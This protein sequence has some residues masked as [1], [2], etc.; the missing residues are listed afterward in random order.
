MNCDLLLE[1]FMV[2]CPDFTVREHMSVAIT[3]N[4]IARVGS[5]AE[6]ADLSAV[7]KLYGDGKLLM[8]G[9]ID[10]HTHTC[11]QL[12]RGSLADEFP[13]VWVR[14]LVPFESALTEDDVYYSA[15]LYCVQAIKSGVTGFADSGGRHMHRVAQA[16]VEAG[17]RAG[18]TRSMM[19]MGRDISD[20]ML[21]RTEEAVE[22]NDLL[23]EQYH[24]A[25]N[26]R[27]SVFYGMR[28][29]MAC[30]EKLITLLAEHAR[31]RNTCVHGHLCEHRDEVSFC[32]QQYRL[33]PAEFLDRC[34]LLG[35]NLLTAHN[36]VLSEPDIMLLAERG[37]KLVHCPFANLINHGV[38]KTPR[39]L[40]AG[41][42]VGLGSDGAAYNSVDIFEE[43]RVLRA[44]VIATWG[45]PIFDPV[46]LTV[47]K[48]LAMATQG[49]AAAMNLGDSLGAIEPG[50]LADL[51][52]IDTRQPHI[53][54]T[55]SYTTALLDCVCARDVS[56]SIIDGVPVMLDRRLLTLDE[57]AIME[58]C[59]VRMDSI[60]R[61]VGR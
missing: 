13:M 47:Q 51:I 5:S 10:A 12:L 15:L 26:G 43:M 25:G 18:I 49:G 59:A 42:S 31:A 61:R 40:E 46:A 56:D 21:E 30:S 57:T 17:I 9:L 34:S 35:P 27:V 48:T 50:R 16:A 36:V 41:C 45:L 55:N 33:R 60:R 39:L 7:K 22:N 28:Q 37:V 23:F 19:D 29:V 3:G 44:A 8:P 52:A 20:G 1:D 6:L 58:E 11:Q 38:P 24:G 4:R 53:R 14:F 2:L 54:P 32:L